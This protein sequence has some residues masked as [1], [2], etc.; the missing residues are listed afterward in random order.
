MSISVVIPNLHSSL[1]G[2]VLTALRQQTVVP[3]EIIVVGQDRHNLVQADELV[4][5]IH[6]PRPISAARARNLGAQ[7]ARGDYILFLDADCLADREL[8]AYMTTLHRQGK[9]IV[10]GGVTFEWLNY[11]TICD[12]L[13][14]FEPFLT[15]KPPGPR[16]YLPSL[17]LSIQR[18]LFVQHGGFDARFPGAAGE[19]VELSL[20]L[21]H[22]GIILWFEPTARVL[23]KPQ[24][25]TAHSVWRHLRAFG[26]VHY[27]V[28]RRYPELSQARLLR[29]DP[30]WFGIL[31]ALIPALALWDAL[32]V[33]L[34]NPQTRRRAT[35]LPGLTW[36]RMGWYVG[37]I[38]GLMAN[39]QKA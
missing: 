22:A 6:T 8:V 32:H 36:G 20:R 10:G 15:S 31:T 13:L 24:R 37:M 26:Q 2:E 11:W 1:I 34:R 18:Q 28:Q 33:L 16:R 27:P 3:C 25:S 23:H 39:P 35:L 12:N 38:E 4:C 5:C 14:A 7:A 19:D 30:R 21:R 9:L 29:R 17:N